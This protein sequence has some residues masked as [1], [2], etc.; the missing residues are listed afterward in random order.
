MLSD[1][2]I[3][4]MLS[5]LVWNDVDGGAENVRNDNERQV[6]GA[7]SARKDNARTPT[8]RSAVKK[9]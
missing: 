8:V 7:D 5:W 3:A 2:V 4:A 6:A 9:K 1:V